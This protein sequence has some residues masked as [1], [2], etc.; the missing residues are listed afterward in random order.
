MNIPQNSAWKTRL[1][2]M[3]FLIA[4]STSTFGRSRE[5]RPSSLPPGN[6]WK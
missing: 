2:N 3:S 6:W 5:M 4:R 1:I